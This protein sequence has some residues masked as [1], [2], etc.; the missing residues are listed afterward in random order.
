MT[1]RYARVKVP[2][3]VI[4]VGRELCCHPVAGATFRCLVGRVG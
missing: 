4:L 3:H 1:E 2:C